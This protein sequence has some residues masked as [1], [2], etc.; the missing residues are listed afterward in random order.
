MTK[1]VVLLPLAPLKYPSGP[2][3]TLLAC[4]NQHGAPRAVAGHPARVWGHT[5]A[6]TPGGVAAGGADD[7]HQQACEVSCGWR[8]MHMGCDTAT[9]GS[10]EPFPTEFSCPSQIEVPYTTTTGSGKSGLQHAWRRPVSPMCALQS[11]EM[12]AVHLLSLPESTA[13]LCTRI[14]PV[15]DSQ[16]SVVRDRPRQ[17]GWVSPLI[18]R[19]FRIGIMGSCYQRRPKGNNVLTRTPQIKSQGFGG[20][21]APIKGCG[22]LE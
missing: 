16:V 11:F 10:P 22:C 15:T 18:P 5:T 13:N 9:V 7:A 8:T 2:P 14:R 1:Q 21:I 4:R 17:E 6:A 3:W 19:V 12:S 20:R